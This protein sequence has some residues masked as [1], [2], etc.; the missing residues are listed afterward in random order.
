MGRSRKGGQYERQICRILSLWWTNGTDDDVFW[1]SSQS[2]GRATTRAKKGK[3]TKGHCGDISATDDVGLPFTKIVT[4]E[5]KR[6]YKNSGISEILDKP[7]KL[8]QS[9]TEGFIQQA[10]EA[11]KRAGT[12]FWML[13]H[14]RDAREPLVYIP[15][16]FHAL[17]RI[18]NERHITCPH[19]FGSVFIKFKGQK[20]RVIVHLAVLSLDAFIEACDPDLIRKMYQKGLDDARKNTTG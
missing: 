18:A 15:A 3:G 6:G 2:G 11:A 4:V 13:I 12:P 8:K 20:K 17:I 1:R 10:R 9:E 16:S 14:K 19:L 7:K 5:I